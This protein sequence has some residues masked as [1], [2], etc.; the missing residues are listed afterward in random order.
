MMPHE[1]NFIWIDEAA[2][3]LNISRVTLHSWIKKYERIKNKNHDELTDSE[4][5]FRC[6]PHGRIGS[7]YRFKKEEIEKFIEESMNREGK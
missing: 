2:L 3:L 5:N 4:K 6:P 7:R 1:R